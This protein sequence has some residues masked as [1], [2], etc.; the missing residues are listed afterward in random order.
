VNKLLDVAGNIEFRFLNEFVSRLFPGKAFPT[1]QLV[2]LALLNPL[3]S[4]P[5]DALKTVE[6]LQ[7]YGRRNF[8]VF[9][10]FL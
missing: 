9:S 2:E 7:K 4:V 5:I 10:A 8:E 6:K 3:F 1:Q